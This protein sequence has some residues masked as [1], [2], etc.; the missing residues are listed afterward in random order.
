MKNVLFLLLL[1]C[2]CTTNNYLEEIENEINMN[3]K[4]FDFVCVMV[5]FSQIGTD[6]KACS[7]HFENDEGMTFI[8]SHSD[9]N[10]HVYPFTEWPGISTTHEYVGKKITLEFIYDVKQHGRYYENGSYNNDFVILSNDGIVELNK[11]MK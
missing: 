2:S 11:Y 4:V 5:N 1:V 10:N 7:L 9:L 8:Y 3:E 6:I